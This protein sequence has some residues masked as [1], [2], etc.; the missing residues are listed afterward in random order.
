MNLYK[1]ETGNLMLDGGAMFGV[2][3]KSI[4][5]KIY[6]GDHNNL[7]N[8]AMRCLLVEDGQ[9]KILIDTGMGN[10]QSEKFFAHYYPN[11]DDTLEGSLSVYGFK[12]EDVTDVILTHL[13]F[14]HVGG[15][16]K[17]EG[18]RYVPTFPNAVYHIGKA[19]WELANNP[20]RREKASYLPENYEVLS[21]MGLV[22][23]IEAEGEHIPGIEFRIFDGHT[24][25]QV[26]PLIHY[27]SKVLAYGGDLFP[28][29]AHI[30]MPYI[31]SYDTQP[32]LTLKDKK[33]FFE[34]ALKRNITIYFEHDL[35]NEC[36]S[37]TETEKGVK[38]D[39]TFTL[40][41]FKI[42]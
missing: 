17:K 7:C 32:L 35:Y 24:V 23:L 22:N 9:R 15:A 42:S 31:M 1:I 2:V 28:S 16:V 37:L 11:G 36:C 27:N 21:E 5:Q 13:H 39:K 30:P 4:W 29:T 33:R 41:E 38:V 40:E 8:W 10:K 6:P 18:D 14:D 20:N 25:G 19:Q 26:I 12:P 34:E 3:P